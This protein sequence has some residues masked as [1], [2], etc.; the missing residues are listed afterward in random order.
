MFT[1][2]KLLMRIDTLIALTGRCSVN[3]MKPEYKGKATAEIWVVLAADL[4]LEVKVNF[5]LQMSTV[6]KKTSII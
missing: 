2:D 4:S 3:R 1:F 6:L 5:Y